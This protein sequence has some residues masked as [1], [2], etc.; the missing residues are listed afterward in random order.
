MLVSNQEYE[1]LLDDV[2][3]EFPDFKVVKKSQSGLMKAIGGFLKVI[4][5]GRMNTFMTSFI[6]TIGTTVYVPDMWDTRSPSAKAI[7][8]RHERVH[9][10]Q[11]RDVGR[12]KFSLLYIFLPVP[13]VWAYYRARFEKEAYEESLKAYHEYYGEKFLTSAL[14]ENI[15]GH[16]TSAE[17]F[18]MWPWK[19]SIEKWYDEVI[20]KIT[21]SN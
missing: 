21:T 2:K 8:M 20:N 16:F 12:L 6:T 5:F 10:R 17:Y 4:T 11:A 19:E 3:S 18:W 7:T 9:M 15:V 13:L 14:K 1:K